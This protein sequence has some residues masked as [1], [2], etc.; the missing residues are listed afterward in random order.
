M[1][2]SSVGSNVDE[3]RRD[4]CLSRIIIITNQYRHAIIS[5]EIRFDLIFGLVERLHR[6]NLNNLNYRRKIYL[7][8]GYSGRHAKFQQATVRS[9]G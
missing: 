9:W 5:V 7:Q 1:Y 8:N 6:F 3:I 4:R 2:G